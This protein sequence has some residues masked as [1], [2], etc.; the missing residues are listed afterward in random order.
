MTSL[1]AMAQSPLGALRCLGLRLLW[2]T[3]GM[4]GVLAAYAYFPKPSS[5]ANQNLADWAVVGLVGILTVA[6]GGV[7]TAFGAYHDLSVNF[8][9]APWRVAQED[10]LAAAA[11][12][13]DPGAAPPLQCPFHRAEPAE[14][15]CPACGTVVSL[16]GLHEVGRR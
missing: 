5:P 12:C 11:T 13:G 16:A 15:Q 6:T 14:A 3:P 2:G 9:C 1:I 10:A 7:L 4:C 8:D